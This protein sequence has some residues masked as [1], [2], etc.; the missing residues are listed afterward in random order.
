MKGAAPSMVR[1]GAKPVSEFYGT[2]QRGLVLLAL[3]TLTSVL[4]SGQ[5][6]TS[7]KKNPESQAQKTATT[8]ETRGAELAE[9]PNAAAE[10][11]EDENAQFKQSASV[12]WIARHL[13]IS[14]ELAYWLCIVINFA[15]VAGL[16]GFALKK[17]LPTFFRDRTAMI[18][19][20]MEDARRASEDANRRLREIEE[21]LG[22][23]DSDIAQL[24]A[25][26][27]KQGD[28]EADRLKSAAE[29][30]RRRIIQTAEQEITAAANA[31][32]RDLK[33]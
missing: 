2:L 10:H 9:A 16:I 4:V 1:A 12:K 13:G 15:V 26:A 18:Q 6:G 5:Q 27:A 23:L 11:T 24:E 8:S 17:K 19:K 22:R 25:T 21:K 28:Q 3:L 20:G 7:E 31:A 32:R 33:A 14:T 29:E 30:E